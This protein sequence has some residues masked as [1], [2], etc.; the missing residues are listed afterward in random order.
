MQQ[1]GCFFIG[2]KVFNLTID[3]LY[4]RV[5]FIGAR[6]RRQEK[7]NS[8]VAR[9]GVIHMTLHELSKMTYDL[10][11]GQYINN[12]KFTLE[13]LESLFRAML[14]KEGDSY[15]GIIALPDG[16]WN[17]KVSLIC[18]TYDLYIPETR[19]QVK[20][21]IAELLAKSSNKSHMVSLSP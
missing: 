4:S 20:R 10:A 7:V 2:K 15:I 3:I 1:H 17:F 14:R 9:K 8:A 16:R 11:L 21:L 5:Y 18:G 6:K 12:E 13:R 19:E